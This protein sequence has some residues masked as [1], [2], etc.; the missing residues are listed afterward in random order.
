[1]RPEC[2][3][4]M[5]GGEKCHSIALRGTKLCHLHTQLKRAI[6][7]A[8]AADS[9]DAFIQF[10]FPDN[11]I[12]VQLAVYQVLN[13]LGRKTVELKRANCMLHALKI[14]AGTLHRTRVPIPFYSVECVSNED[15][16]DLGPQC[17]THRRPDSCDGCVKKPSCVHFKTNPNQAVNKPAKPKPVYTTTLK[18]LFSLDE[19]QVEQLTTL[20]RPAYLER[21]RKK[22]Q[23]NEAASATQRLP[24]GGNE[25]SPGRSPGSGPSIKPAAP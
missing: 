3:Y 18:E 22:E 10:N 19:K 6:D 4:I 25:F 11:M 1:M 9:D 13:A 8:A 17:E 24:E 20:L 16:M 2:R 15:G 23:E 5:T 21:E 12:G 14:L 7:Q